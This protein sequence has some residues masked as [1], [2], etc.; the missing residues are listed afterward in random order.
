M[1]I[2]KV[3]DINIEYYVEGD[4]PPLLLIQGF[5]GSANDWGERILQELR[6]HFRVV[7]LSN[8]GTG[9]TDRPKVEY[10]LEM[11]ADDAAGLLGELG[12]A[13]AHVLGISMGGRIAQEL[14]LNHPEVVQGL[15]LGCTGPGGPEGVAP[16]AEAYALLAPKPGL[17]PEDQI[18]KSWPAIYTPGFIDRERD[19]LEE[20]LRIHL[21]HPTPRD[22]LGRQAAA[23]MRSATY[24]RLS[25][26]QAPTLI[27]HGDQDRL[28]PVEN[29][30]ILRDRIPNSALHILPDAGHAFFTEKP[31]E[32]AEAIVKFLSSVSAPV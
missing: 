11:M 13:S 31:Q 15:V 14:A 6:P 8:R 7:R 19:Y 10:S 20:M 18:R 9:L 4:G 29:A 27:I 28:S 5:S 3:G 24:E 21:K 16:S 1:P 22:T 17:A 23:S 12:I 32:T 30:H 26:I 2:T 25:D